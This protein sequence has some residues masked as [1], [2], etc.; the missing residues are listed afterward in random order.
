MG[1]HSL[2][3]TIEILDEFI[4]RE[5]GRPSLEPMRTRILRKRETLA[6]HGEGI[7]RHLRGSLGEKD[8]ICV[9]GKRFL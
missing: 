7:T 9:S 6:E 4:Q 1:V 5:G 8:V 2:Q 3:L